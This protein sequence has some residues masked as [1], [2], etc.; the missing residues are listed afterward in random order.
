MRDDFSSKTNN[1]L[2][3]RANFKCSF[4]DCGIPTSSPN[5]SSPDGVT[6]IGV[7]AHIHAA[8]PGGAR[9]LPSMSSEERTSISNGIWLCPTHGTLID[10]DTTAYTAEILREMKAVHETQIQSAMSGL[11]K[12][13]INLIALG[14]DPV[15]SGEL[16]AVKGDTW[17]F[18]ILHFIIGDLHT[19]ISFTE[20]YEQ[21]DPYD[22]YILV[23]SLGDGRQMA[24][25]PELSKLD[26][27]FV[28][29]AKVRNSFPRINAQNLP[30]DFALNDAHDLFV[31]NGNF[32]E[33][34]GL[35]NLPQRI[36]VVK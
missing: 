29:T 11:K 26:S 5:D 1:A 8:S 17:Q 36:V 7:A 16:I 13:N 35:D 18:R 33:V 10:R 2:A 34:S 9:Y 28:V 14:P 20:R 6:K 32:A 15:F 27:E 3:L 23:N 19:L 24:E 22:R 30:R 31:A 25:P 21:I 12:V 4:T